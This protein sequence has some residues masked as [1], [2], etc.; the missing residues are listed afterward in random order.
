MK[1]GSTI[2]KVCIVNDETEKMVNN[3][4][5]VVLKSLKISSKFLYYFMTCNKFKRSNFWFYS[6]RIHSYYIP[7][8]IS[9]HYILFPP[10]EQ[11]NQISEFL[12][13]QTTQF[14]EL[15]TNHAQIT[16]LKEKQALITAAVT[17]KIDVRDSV[18]A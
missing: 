15:I 14:D 6:R 9:N 1:T 12:D 2:G 16:L 18:V 17:G 10:P 8:K 13:K 4:Q 7:R 11:Q 3:P 5:L